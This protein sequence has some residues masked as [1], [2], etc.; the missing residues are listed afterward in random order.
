MG[1]GK[2]TSA[3]KTGKKRKRETDGDD[4]GGDDSDDGIRMEPVE[5][6]EADIVESDEEVEKPVARR[7]GKERRIEALGKKRVEKEV[8]RKGKERQKMKQD[9]SQWSR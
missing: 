5:V 1:E 3:G 7:G 2:S 4:H 6:N 8:Y 9:G